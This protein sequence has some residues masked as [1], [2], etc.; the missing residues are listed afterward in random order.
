M[1]AFKKATQRALTRVGHVLYNKNDS[2]AAKLTF[3]GM[4][5]VAD[6]RAGTESSL[7]YATS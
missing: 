2:I 5:A 7:F 6:K 4:L 1:F 3:M